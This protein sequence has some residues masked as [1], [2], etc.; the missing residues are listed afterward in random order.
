MESTAFQGNSYGGK[1]DKHRALHA[2]LSHFAISLI[3]RD[4]VSVPKQQ[5]YDTVVGLELTVEATLRPVLSV[6]DLKI[7]IKNDSCHICC[8]LT[9]VSIKQVRFLW[10]KNDEATSNRNPLLPIR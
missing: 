8:R 4:D 5:I 2:P 6:S 10:V 9:E 7:I 3:Q 1:C